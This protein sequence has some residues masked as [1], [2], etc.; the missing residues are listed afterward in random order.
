MTATQFPGSRGQLAALYSSHVAWSGLAVEI[1][2]AMSGLEAEVRRSV[3][4]NAANGDPSLCARHDM[5][6]RELGVD[7][8]EARPRV[9]EDRREP[10]QRDP[11]CPIGVLKYG[12]AAG[13]QAA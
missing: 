6:G 2:R 13:V 10:R 7:R 11:D 12:V 4:P 5:H 3:P 8:P 1:D 9:H